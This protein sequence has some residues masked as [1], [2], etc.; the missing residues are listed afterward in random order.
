[1]HLAL[2]VL[3][4]LVILAMTLYAVVCVAVFVYQRSLIYYPQPMAD[5]TSGEVLNLQVDTQT[6]AISTN[7]RP[8]PSAVIYFGGNAED[9]SQEIPG[10]SRAF[11]RSAI[12]SLQYPGYGSSSGTP[13]E[14]AIFADALTLFDHVKVEH[15]DVVVIGRSLGSCVAVWVASQRPLKRLVLVTPFDSL[16][17]AAA[18][19]FP[20]LPVRWLLRDRYQLGKYAPAVTAPTTMIVAADDEIIPRASSDELHA[21]FRPGVASYVVIAGFGHNTIQN[22]TEY[23]PLLSRE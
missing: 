6:V 19:Q 12:Y 14:K 5:R 2:R 4:G 10:L 11:P 18:N 21:R 9:V 17:D 13:S 22:S 15:P 20:Y 16:A 8:G 7:P 1:M 23:W 3:S